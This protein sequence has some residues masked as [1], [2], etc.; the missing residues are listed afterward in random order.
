MCNLLALSHILKDRKKSLLTCTEGCIVDMGWSRVVKAD[1][2]DINTSSL[3]KMF[4]C[5]SVRGEGGT[6]IYVEIC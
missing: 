2:A 5:T 3:T 1:I 6:V 4:P